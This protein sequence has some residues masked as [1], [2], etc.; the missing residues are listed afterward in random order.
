MQQAELI[1]TYL[2]GE[3]QEAQRQEFEQRLTTDANLRSAVKDYQ[4]ILEGFKAMRQEAGQ[5]EIASWSLEE[6]PDEE[7]VLLMAY[8]EGR[9]APAARQTFEQ[10]M[11]RDPELKRQVESQQAILQGFKGMQHEAFAAEVGQW[12]ASLPRAGK[13]PEA[14]IVP[15]TSKKNSW[16]YAAAAAVLILIAAAFWMLAPLGGDNFSYTAFRQEHYILPADL[17][18]RGNAEDALIA[19]ARDFR[20]KNYSAAIEK[21]EPIPTADSLFVT[22]RY[23]MGHSYY[24]LGQYSQA[25]AAFSE[26]LQPSGSTSYD[27]SNFNRDNAAWT[28]I[29]AQVA[30]MDENPAPSF[31]QELQN[32]LTSFLENADPS[33]T[34]YANGIKLREALFSS[35]NG[36]Q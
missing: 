10:A 32:F 17:M 36:N 26:S 30:L 3:L 22:A 19:A 5:E 20:Q 34:Y 25:V 14:K 16:R 28:R 6:D 33:D 4:T 11:A 21:L 12:A 9:M 35:E 18:D 24:Q 31:R 8:V 13:T 29:L 15:L 27:L 1:I 2:K 23:W 7:A